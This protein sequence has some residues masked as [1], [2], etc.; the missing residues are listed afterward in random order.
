MLSIAS[1]IRHGFLA[2]T[3]DDLPRLLD[4]DPMDPLAVAAEAMVARAPVS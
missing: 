1:V 4:E 2:G 3:G